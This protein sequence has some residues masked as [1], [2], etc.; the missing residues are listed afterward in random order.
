M[1]Y[2]SLHLMDE[3]PSHQSKAMISTYTPDPILSA[4]QG[5]CSS[6]SSFSSTSSTSPTLADHSHHK[7]IISG[8]MKN[9]VD[10]LLPLLQPHFSLT[11]NYFKSCSCSL[12]L[13]LLFAFFLESIPIILLTSKLLLWRL[14]GTP[15][16]LN[17][18]N[19]SQCS[20]SLIHKHSLT[21]LIRLSSLKDFLYLFI[22]K[23]C[24][25]SDFSPTSLASLSQF[26]CFYTKE[27]WE[28]DIWLISYWSLSLMAL[29]PT[30]QDTLTSTNFLSPA[31]SSLLN[32]RLGYLSVLPS[33]PFG[34]AGK[35]SVCNA[36]DLG[37]IPWWGRSPEEGK[38][39]PLQYSGLENSMD[40]TVHGVAK[41]RTWL[42]YFHFH[43]LLSQ[44]PVSLLC[45]HACKLLQ[46][47][48]THCEPMDC[49]PPGS[50]VRGILQARIL[51]W[52]AVPSSR[53][54]PQLRDETLASYI[55]CTGMW[56]LYHERR[57][58][59]PAL[60]LKLRKATVPSFQMPN[61]KPWSQGLSFRPNPHY[62]GLYSNV[63]FSLSSF[64]VTIV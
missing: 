18:E 44:T 10:S 62:A 52:G 46:S 2:L 3:L 23:H 63:I 15:A 54:S 42:S 22:S 20:S 48:P 27:N 17:L 14:P 6:I 31:Q 50:S 58:E 30:C 51:R 4:T 8:T 64:Q 59:S 55:S 34:S 29:K 45:M 19:S 12:P 26:P 40:Y 47:C 28:S 35:E 5:H 33:F 11:N 9:S 56:S 13:N 37:S 25:F 41:S 38:G 36:R 57:L 24:K 49:S 60:P 39:Y 53:G 1:L 16:L 32:Y 7:H 61:P 43:F 21:Q